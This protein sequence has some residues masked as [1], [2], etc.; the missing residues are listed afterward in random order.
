MG[1]IPH[2]AVTN[3]F[4]PTEGNKTSDAPGVVFDPT[5]GEEETPL[6]NDSFKA[7]NSPP[8]GGR[9]RSFCRDWQANNCSFNVL[10]IITNG[11]VLP[12]LS[13]PNLVRFPLILSE[14]KAL[15]K[16]QALADCIQS[17]L[18]KN[19]I[20]RVENVKSLGFYS[21]LF[22][23]PKVEASNRPKQAQHFS[24]RK[25][26]QDGNSRVHQDLPD[27]RGMGSVDRSIGRLPSHP[28]PSSLKEIP[29]ILPQVSGVPVHLPTFRTGHSPPGL[30]HDRK[31]GEAHGL[32]QRAQTPPIPGRLADQVSIPGGSP[33]EHSGSGRSNPVLGMDHQS[34]KIRTESHSGVFVCGLRAPP[35]FSPCKTH[36]REMAQ[37]SGFYPTTQV[38]TC[39][40]CKMFDVSNWVASLN[41]E[42]GLRG[43]ISH[44]ALSVSPQGALE[45]SSTTEQPP[46]LDRSHLC[47]PRLV[48]EPCKRDKRLRLSSQRP[49]YPTLYRRLK[50]R[51]GRSLRT[52][53][54]PRSV[55]SP[56]KRPSHKRPRI[57]S[58]LSGPETLQRPVSGPNSASCNGQLN[59]GSLHKQT[60]RNT[61]SGDVCT[62][63]ENHDLVPSFSHHIESQAHS[64]VSE[65]DG[66]PTFQVKSGTVD[67]M[68][69]TSTGVQTDLPKVVHSPHGPV[70]H[71]AEPQ[72]STVRVSYPR[73][74][75]LGHR[76]SKHRLDG[77]HCLCLP[78]NGSP[79]Q[80]DPKNQTM[81]LSDHTN[82]PRLARDALV[83]GPS[84]AINRDPTATPGVNNTPQA[85]PQL[86]VPQEPAAPQPPRLV[87]RSGQLQEQGFPVE[88]AER[89]AAPQWSSTRTIYKS[90]WAL[91]EKW[92]RENSVDFSTP[93]VK[94]ISDF[95]MYLYQDLSRRPST[96]DGYRTA[97]VDT[98]AHWAN[99]LLIMRNFI[100]C[101]PVSTG[102]DPKVPEISPSGT[103]LLF[104]M[105]S[106]KHPLSL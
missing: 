15:P 69:T 26:V 93:S 54:Y 3:S 27:S 36:S 84:A 11:Y 83:L 5:I 70:C 24:T 20:E 22:L 79:S 94:Q 19:T 76:C 65:C 106:Q 105:S 40:D 45:I 28:H 55:V 72:A 33:S 96:I 75:G 88:V 102:I 52:K 39:F 101:S 44:E 9:L 61:L 81:Q 66:R 17:L 91:F 51:L 13:K 67:R 6:P 62:P 43:T 80:G 63:V 16:D 92:C 42:N 30:Y 68:V 90:K 2:K 37:T 46:S 98:L 23:V 4:L 34:A 64:R 50:R 71:S 8:V 103:F 14:Y 73:P 99:I 85:V 29:K 59:C 21:Q 100:G 77:S 48:A 86:R 95:F 10:N 12:F 78:S 104:S 82:S 47:T 60:R 87:S 18:S 97:I 74:E 35:R 7:S 53:F 38:K 56:G 89:I 41:G 1:A 57:E 58:C 32:L 25:E 49:Q 31:G